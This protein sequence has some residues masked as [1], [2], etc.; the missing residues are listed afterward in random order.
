MS[1]QALFFEAFQGIL[2]RTETP[3][4]RVSVAVS[5]GADSMALALLSRE[6]C[7]IHDIHLIAL[8]VDHGLRPE[9]AQEAECVKKW[10]KDHRIAHET[11]LWQPEDTTVTQDMAREARYNLLLSYCQSHQIDALLLGH[12]ALDQAETILMRF[13]KGSGL[14]GLRGMEDISYRDSV[15]ILR[16]LLAFWPDQLRH[17][18][19]ERRQAWVE[20][21]SN[22]QQKYLRVIA[23]DLL[24]NECSPIKKLGLEPNKLLNWSQKFSDSHKLI[25]A[26]V[27]SFIDGFV[28]L[29]SKP[30]L[31]SRSAFADTSPLLRPYIM[32]FVLAH[33]I[34]NEFP[35]RWESLC[36]TAHKIS[37]G[38]SAT[39][40]GYCFMVGQKSIQVVA[41]KRSKKSVGD[42]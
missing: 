11:L 16:P 4:H 8:T 14:R 37:Q 21:P 20:D 25:E 28:Q 17:Y 32:E 12:H 33:L 23:R 2:A 24:T 42:N 19:A 27:Q 10:L 40:G 36:V 22:H 29:S 1:L 5:G 39:L 26:Q 15:L 34:P 30:V 38:Q 35:P 41:E 7:Q 3:P 31:I 9:S 18:L 13:C 6:F